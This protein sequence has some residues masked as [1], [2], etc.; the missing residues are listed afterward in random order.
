MPFAVGFVL[1][2]LGAKI[3]CHR[4]LRLAFQDLGSVRGGCDR[5]AH[6][7]ERGGQESMM[8]VVR[9]REP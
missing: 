5:I 3:G 8:R 4:E 2:V 6:L 9:P 7:R 1:V